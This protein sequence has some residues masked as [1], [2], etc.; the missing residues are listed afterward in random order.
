MALVYLLYAELN[1]IKTFK[2]M[3]GFDYLILMKSDASDDLTI[4]E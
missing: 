1:L 4:L 2:I 3:F